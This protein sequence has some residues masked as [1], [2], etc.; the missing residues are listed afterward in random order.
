MKRLTRGRAT[1]STANLS[2]QL[3][4]CLNGKRKVVWKSVRR[5]IEKHEEQRAHKVKVP[6][7]KRRRSDEKSSE[8][9]HPKKSMLIKD[10]EDLIS[11]PNV[12]DKQWNLFERDIQ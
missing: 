5:F 7:R 6:S 9:D 2:H 4:F 10:R 11:Q 1:I 8:R 12:T 3:R